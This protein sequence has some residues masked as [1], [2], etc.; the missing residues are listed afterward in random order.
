MPFQV[1]TVKQYLIDKVGL[2]EGTG[3]M[4][5]NGSFVA[6][7]HIVYP[8]DSLK[9]FIPGLGGGR[10]KNRD[11][12]EGGCICCDCKRKEQS[13]YY[14]I[15]QLNANNKELV[16]YLKS[17]FKLDD[18]FC[19]CKACKFRAERQ[20][21]P[22]SPLYTSTKKARLQP[23]KCVLSQYGQCDQ[24]GKPCNITLSDILSCFDIEDA[25]ANTTTTLLCENHRTVFRQRC[26]LQSHCA[27]CKKW[28][29][30]IPKRSYKT[31]CL[32]QSIHKY[33]EKQHIVNFQYNEDDIVC[34]ACFVK[35]HRFIS[36]PPHFE[37][38][39]LEDLMRTYSNSNFEPDPEILSECEEKA[40]C[41]VIV[42]ICTTFL[43]CEGCLLQ[44][45][46]M[47]YCTTLLENTI[48]DVE[49]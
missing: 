41:E 17:K 28:L 24:F 12:H 4:L 18:T 40:F 33:A 30:T 26:E 14:H 38:S 45:M 22:R 27:L 2:G 5:V 42:N 3:R 13:Y 10:S 15:T 19:V 44:E 35:V 32:E 8:S 1:K 11:K 48:L 36:K 46:Y 34:G 6:D 21:M 29:G 31:S 39:Q 49:A 16:A 7:N 25:P 47:T 20:M 23:S 43:S 9:I 37:S